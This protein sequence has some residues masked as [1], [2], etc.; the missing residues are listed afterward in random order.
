MRSIFAASFVLATT[1]ALTGCAVDVDRADSEQAGDTSE[2]QG[3]LSVYGSK[4][5]GSYQTTNSA[6]DFDVITL[7]A[8]G[9]YTA[10]EHVVCITA[11]CP[12]ILQQGKYIAYKPSGKSFLGGLRLMPKKGASSFY[13]VSLGTP[14][15]S[16]KLS[17]DG[18]KTFY[19]YEA[20]KPVFACGTR[21]GVACATG[22]F[23]ELKDY[24]CGR[25]DQGGACLAQPT[26][27]TK[28][29]A[30]VCG[31]DGVTYGNECMRRAAGASKDFDG[32]C[33]PVVVAEPC[34]VGG[35]SS[36]LCSDKEGLMSTCLF[37]PEYACYQ[38]ATC[39]RQ[40]D[41]A[42][43]WTSTKALTACIAAAK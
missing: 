29:Y 8:N 26:I 5:V 34:F 4:L 3:A 43:G 10:E 27:C 11:P 9:T 24:T 16:F 15:E 21:G 2:V 17:R 18:G 35:C 36:Q 32:E 39:E 22:T 33:A 7:K 20:K 31:C 28:E 25:L 30:P 1:I 40:A 23:C 13:L 6:S 42:C 12:A 14:N 38:T 41:G 19:A 37:K